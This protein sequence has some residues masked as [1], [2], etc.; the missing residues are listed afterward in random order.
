MKRLVI[1]LMLVLVMLALMVTPVM[2]KGG[3][4]DGGT[5]IQDGILTYAAN[6]YLAGQPL[7]TGYDIYG[8]NYQAHLFKG[9]Y[10]NTYL[11][12][13]GFP[14][15][16]GDTEA[17]VAENPTVTGKWYWPYRDVKLEMKWNDAWISNMDRDG[18]G[19]LDRHYGYP[20][21]IGSG[22]WETNHQWGEDNGYKWNYFCK[23]VAA[24]ADAVKTGGVWYT[25]DGIE[26]GPDIWGEFAVIQ[27][28]YNDQGTGEHGLVYKSPA[29]AG[30]GFYQ[31]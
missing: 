19:K 17:Y 20:S 24:P 29:A 21:Y 13:E 7:K 12:A 2:A 10:A 4:K 3:Q 5:T 31:P 15:Y 26:I 14:P 16:E 1:A 11:G 25:A 9:S 28:V 27:E 30:F 6:H 22:A 23:I 18:D 8:Y